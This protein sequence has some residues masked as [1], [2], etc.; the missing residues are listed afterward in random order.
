MAYDASLDYI[1]WVIIFRLCFYLNYSIDDQSF[2]RLYQTTAAAT[3]SQVIRFHYVE[4]VPAYSKSDFQIFNSTGSSHR[5][6][7][8][9]YLSN[10]FASHSVGFLCHQALGYHDRS[11]VEIF[12]YFYDRYDD[13]QLKHDEIYH[14]FLNNI[15]HFHDVRNHSIS[16]IVEIIRKDQLDVLVFLDSS[17][18]SVGWEVLAMR[19]C[20]VQVSWLGGDSPGLP[21]IDYFLVD[22]YV[23]TPDSQKDYSE[24]LLRLPTFIATDQFAVENLNLVKFRAYLNIPETSVIYWTSSSAYKRNTEC[25][26]AQLDIIR[27]V[28]DCVLVIRGMSDLPAMIELY[29]RMAKEKGV[30]DKLRFL[31]I[32][33]TPARHRAELELA[34]I[35]LD[36]FPYTG[37]T[38]TMEALWRGVPVLTKVGQHYYGANELYPRYKIIG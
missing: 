35:M 10:T 5:P 15:Q 31:A 33:P 20:P 6:L 8:V 22:P 24:Q 23:L 7:K 27:Q 32:A 18:N 30:A 29:K 11:Q 9:G 37:A 13:E 16:E 25:V 19:V 34:D 28:E 2:I 36:T 3:Y 17:T 21:E 12:A 38:Q 26:S 14:F 1:L 4:Q